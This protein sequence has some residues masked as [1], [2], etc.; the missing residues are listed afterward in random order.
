MLDDSLAVRRI[1][2]REVEQLG[3]PHSLLETTGGK[4]VLALRL[5]DPDG[6]PGSDLEQVVRPEG[7]AAPVFAAHH[8][9]APVCDRVLLGDLIRGPARVV[10]PRDDVVPAGLYL[11]RAESRHAR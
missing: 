9:D 11:E 10:K 8:D 7:V 2:E 5:D 3:V 4:P 1:G 6:E